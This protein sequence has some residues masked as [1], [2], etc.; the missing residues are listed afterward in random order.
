MGK[1]DTRSETKYEDDEQGKHKWH[2]HY[3]RARLFGMGTNSSVDCNG[4]S[5]RN[6]DNK[7]PEIHPVNDRLWEAL[8]YRAHPLVE[9]SSHY[10]DEVE[11]SI[12]KWVKQ[13]KKQMKSSVLRSLDANLFSAFCLIS[14]WPRIRTWCIR[15]WPFWLLQLFTK[16]PAAVFLNVYNALKSTTQKRQLEDTVTSYYEVLSSHIDMCATEDVIANTS[17]DM[18]KCT[19]VWNKS[20][21]EYAKALWNSMQRCNR[22]NDKYIFKGL[23]IES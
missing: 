14:S 8:H 21:T 16:R 20:S 18:M 5:C 6:R 12:A 17:V 3:C 22:V 10:N 19:Q 23:Y 15:E 2:I 13:L 11:R 1:Y 4:K 9:T 7:L